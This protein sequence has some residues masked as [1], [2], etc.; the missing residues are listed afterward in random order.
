VVNGTNQIYHD[1]L[2]IDGTRLV[3]T[4]NFIH[5][6]KNTGNGN[7]LTN[8]FQLDMDSVNTRYTVYVDAMSVVYTT[9]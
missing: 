9:Y 5:N 8:A 2:T 1:S 4:Q 6:A 7:Q 3:P